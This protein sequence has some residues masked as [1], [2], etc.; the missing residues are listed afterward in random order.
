MHRRY[1]ARSLRVL[2]IAHGHFFIVYPPRCL[3]IPISMTV[4]QSFTVSVVAVPAGGELD[5]PPS[6]VQSAAGVLSLTPS[7]DGLS[8]V[9]KALAPGSDTISVKDVSQGTPIAGDDVVVVTVT[10][11]VVPST[12]LHVTVSTPA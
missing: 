7:A 8:C 4:G 5:G 2:A 1:R 12:A 10:A 6:Y 11:P 3:M 9:V